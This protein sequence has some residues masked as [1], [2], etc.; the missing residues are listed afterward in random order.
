MRLNIQIII[1]TIDSMKLLSM[2]VKQ[3]EHQRQKTAQEWLEERL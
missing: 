2:I 3:L 1:A